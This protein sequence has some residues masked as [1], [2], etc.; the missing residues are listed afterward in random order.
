MGK[1]VIA[2]WKMNK[3]SKEAVNFCRQL[4]K[5]I[6]ENDN[7]MICPPATL[8]QT[9]VSELRGKINVGAQN[10]YCEQSG[11]FTGEISASMAQD[12]GANAVIVGHSE[13]RYVFGE[14]NELVAR[15][16]KAVTNCGLMAVL[17][18]G[19]RLEE[20]SRLKSVLKKQLKAL[21]GVSLDKVI[22]AYE[23][24]WAIG[25]GK[26]ANIKDINFAHNYIIEHVS[27]TYGKCPKV[28]Y[29]GS[30]KPENAR[31]IYALD[32]VSGVLVGGASLD[33]DKFA[34]LVTLARV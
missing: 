11:A 7:V 19:E 12:A 23:P 4:L 2:N 22:I 5:V 32:C 8:I 28:L 16:L 14:S 26:V 30:V 25:T 6:T 18:V 21:D 13:R 15:K 27:K 20:H 33:A 17:C 24:V 31:E 3:T 34:E 9:I 10:V 1:I 29:G